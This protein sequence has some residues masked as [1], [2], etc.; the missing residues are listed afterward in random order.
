MAHR[1]HQQSKHRYGAHGTAVLHDMRRAYG[2]IG[3]RTALA[4][5]T[6]RN[7]PVSLMDELQLIRTILNG[8]DRM[9]TEAAIAAGT[10]SP[11]QPTLEERAR[12]IREQLELLSDAITQGIRQRVDRSI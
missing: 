10:I 8:I 12:D 5:P 2:T 1:K 11:L 9:V 4:I 7:I 6:V 3:E